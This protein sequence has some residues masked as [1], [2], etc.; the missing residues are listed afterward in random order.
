MGRDRAP[1]R[2]KSAGGAA[3]TNVVALHRRALCRAQHALDVTGISGVALAAQPPTGTTITESVDL[4]GGV[5][6]EVRDIV[7]TTSQ[8]SKHWYT[9]RERPN[10]LARAARRDPLG[11]F[12]ARLWRTSGMQRL[13]FTGAK[14]QLVEEGLVRHTKLDRVATVIERQPLRVRQRFEEPAEP[15]FDDD[16]HFVTCFADL[17]QPVLDRINWSRLDRGRLGDDGINAVD[18][19]RP[20]RLARRASTRAR[21]CGH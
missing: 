7:R 1:A 3:T 6:G 9:P 15:G 12:R 10:G 19:N 5:I 16:N 20:P 17:G 8:Y 13:P 2:S 14:H 18:A 11:E 4:E 21:R